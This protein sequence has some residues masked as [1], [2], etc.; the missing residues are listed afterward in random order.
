MDSPSKALK[1]KVLTS[2]LFMTLSQWPFSNTYAA[3]SPP[4]LINVTGNYL[5]DCQQITGGCGSSSTIPRALGAY[6]P[7][8]P[9]DSNMQLDSVW[10]KLQRA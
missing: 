6:A 9:F 1:R 8:A 5:S 7:L 4:G 2:V 10:I 3:Y